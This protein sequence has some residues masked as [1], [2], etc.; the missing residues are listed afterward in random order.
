MDPNGGHQPITHENIDTHV[1]SNGEIYNFRELLKTHGLDGLK[2]GSD[3]ES[4]I[5]LYDKFGPEFIKELNGMF[6]F[7]I[8]R[9]DGKEILAARDH[10]GIKPLYH[11]KGK[12]GE[13][14]FA[15]ELKCIVDQDCDSI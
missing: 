6:G 14:Y 1:V 11:G 13:D 5:L 3:S 9:N 8:A 12:N 7:V 4:L 15:S 10:C 2:T